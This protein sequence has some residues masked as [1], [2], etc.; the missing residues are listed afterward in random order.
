MS[1]TRPHF[2]ISK[3]GYSK[4]DVDNF[5]DDLIEENTSLETRNIL[6][7]KESA[8][9]NREVDE[10][11]KENSHLNT[12]LKE[13]EF[14]YSKMNRFALKEANIIINAATNDADIIVNEA[15]NEAKIIIND[16]KK[17]SDETKI[18]KSL[19]RSKLSELE[20]NLDTLEFNEKISLPWLN[21]QEQKK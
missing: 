9:L 10:L 7:L 21:N 6:L 3:N 12:K 13:N 18:T 14:A 11:K 5:I 8:I 15:L 17:L 19:L 20:K 4:V 2:K 1:I 16:I